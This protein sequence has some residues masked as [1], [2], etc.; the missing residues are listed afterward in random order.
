M[1]IPDMLGTKVATRFK[2]GKLGGVV[3]AEI[4][5][6]TSKPEP[7]NATD[8]RWRRL[9]C[10]CDENYTVGKQE[11]ERQERSRTPGLAMDRS[12]KERPLT[13]ATA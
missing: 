12:T 4:S 7:E 8:A 9:A 11:L 5:L 3:I 1:I 2:R 10:F 6:S 13:G